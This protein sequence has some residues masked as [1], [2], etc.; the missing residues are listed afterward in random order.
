M[1]RIG[2]RRRGLTLPAAGR[3]SAA[4]ADFVAAL[5]ILAQSLDTEG[6]APAHSQSLAQGLAALREP[7]EFIP[8]PSQLE[9]DLD[10][11]GIIARHQTPILK[12]VSASTLTPLAAFH[13]YLAFGQE[14]LAAGRSAGRWPGPWPC[15]A[16][17][18]FTW[19]WPNPRARS[20]PWIE[21]GPGVLPGRA[22]GLAAELHGGQR[23]GGGA[24]K[25]G[26]YDAA[27]DKLEQSVVILPQA[28]G[29]HNLSVVYQ[30]SA[31]PIRPAG[32]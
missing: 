27:R 29:L 7:H 8:S 12:Q 2:Q 20:S 18:N 19:R 26:Q 32:P 22:G 15:M 10:L 9:A 14:R 25:G 31:W 6:Q 30:R 13:A 3:T 5:R 1:R 24:G 16:W 4:R 28:A 11:G 23:P 21:Q 17:E